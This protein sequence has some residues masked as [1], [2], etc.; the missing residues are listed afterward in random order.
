MIID[1]IGTCGC[2]EYSSL[3]S[4]ELT[5]KHQT[6]TTI[7]RS[8]SMGGD[9]IKSVVATLRVFLKSLPV[10]CI[11]NIVQFDNSFDKLFKNS[12]PYNEVSL[13]KAASFVDQI[14]ENGGTEMLPAL[15][16]V[17]ES[18]PVEGYPRQ[19]FVL[20]DGEISNT[21]EVLSLVRRFAASVRV[22]SFGIGNK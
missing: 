11:F 19:V 10:N 15:K 18:P 8:G 3:D 7:D 9:P 13:K 12:E 17:L 2:F 6:N 1:S 16:A 4:N 5:P 20:T 21:E 14:H 22:F